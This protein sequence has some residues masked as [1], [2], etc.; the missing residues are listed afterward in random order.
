MSATNNLA[1]GINNLGSVPKNLV[2]GIINPDPAIH[3]H[4]SVG[5]IR[6]GNLTELARLIV[7]LTSEL[8][9]YTFYQQNRIPRSSPHNKLG[10]IPAS[11]II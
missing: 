11:V 10:F 3:K 9:R 6:L 8:G 2:Y 7:L 5:S 4:E 1:S